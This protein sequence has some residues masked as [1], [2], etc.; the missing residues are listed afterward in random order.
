MELTFF[1]L[2]EIKY[3]GSDTSKI[4]GYLNEAQQ[5]VAAHE[6]T[7]ISFYVNVM[8]TAFERQYAKR[9]IPK[10]EMPMLTPG[11]VRIANS[12]STNDGSRLPCN[13]A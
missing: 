1:P 4:T 2:W 9:Q 7:T 8:F 6:V 10:E 12:R 5:F 11:L 13:R 3:E